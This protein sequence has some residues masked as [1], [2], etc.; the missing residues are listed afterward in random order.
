MRLESIAK[1][2]A[3]KSPMFSDSPRATASERLTGTDV[4]TA[5][6]LAG[7]K[8][9]FGFD[10]YLAK[11]G[12]SSPDRAM[13]ALY[14]S[15]VEISRRYKAFQNSMKACAAE[16]LKLCVLLHTRITHAARQAC[17]G[18]IA[19]MEKVLSKLRCSLIKLPSHGERRRTGRKCPALLVRVTGKSGVQFV[20]WSRS[21]ARPVTERVLSAIRVAAMGK[22]RCWIRMSERQGVP[23]NKTC[24]R[25]SGRGYA[26]LK[27]STVLEGIRTVTDIKK[28]SGYEQYQPLFEDLVGEC[29]KQESYADIMLSKVTM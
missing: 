23:V 25:C 27:F 1:Y 15:A 26:R 22:G 19:A 14:E 4:M 10:L 29:H 9:G 21:S 24:D 5:L 18:V 13:E 7:S 16:F 3:P 28:T 6:G 2:F 12:I 11:I 20:K 8:C 17:A